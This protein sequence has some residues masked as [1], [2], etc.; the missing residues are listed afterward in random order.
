ME[1][2][3]RRD[4]LFGA[5]RPA[6]LSYRADGRVLD[7]RTTLSLSLQSIQRAPPGVDLRAPRRWYDFRNPNRWDRPL[8][9]IAC[10]LLWIGSRRGGQGGPQQPLQCRR[11]TRGARL[12]VGTGGPG[13]DCRRDGLW[14]FAGFRH[15][16]AEG[17]ALRRHARR[18]VRVPWRRASV[19]R[20]RTDQWFRF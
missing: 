4:R 3:G 9:R 13:G 8:D 16:Q 20:R 12:R 2:K 5:L 19:C 11:R 6:N 18:H 17:A 15:H 14:F 1:T 7:R 10:R